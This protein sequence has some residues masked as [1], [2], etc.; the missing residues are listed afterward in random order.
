MSKQRSEGIRG[1]CVRF[2]VT[3]PRPHAS[4]PPRSHTPTN[5]SLSV[6]AQVSYVELTL[7]N[8]GQVVLLVAVMFLREVRIFAFQF[9]ARMSY[10]SLTGG[11]KL[12]EGPMKRTIRV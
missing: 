3:L 12:S 4:L 8:I 9:L 5:S 2:S 7:H 11:L 10:H 6:P 1:E